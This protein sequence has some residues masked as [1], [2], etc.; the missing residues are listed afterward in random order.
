MKNAKSLFVISFLGLALLS[1]VGCSARQVTD[2]QA[3]AASENLDPA[4][5]VVATDPRNKM[6][7]HG[8]R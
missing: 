4:N 5:K 8:I 1:S 3:Y 6:A 2:S 7:A